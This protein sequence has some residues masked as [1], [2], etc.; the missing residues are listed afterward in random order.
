LENDA[1]LRQ[2]F[3]EEEISHIKKILVLPN[4]E[5]HLNKII[6]IIKLSGTEKKT[7]TGRLNF[8]VIFSDELS[9]KEI[10][11]N[12]LHNTWKLT[13]ANKID[14]RVWKYQQEQ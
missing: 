14:Y 9:P 2:L 3:T 13:P 1:K 8:H 7:E 12:F 10:E 4:I 5:F 6:Q 11:E